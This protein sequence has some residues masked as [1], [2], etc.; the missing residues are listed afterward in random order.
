MGTEKVVRQYTKD[1]FAGRCCGQR[2]TRHVL[3][4]KRGILGV[5]FG[6]GVATVDSAVWHRTSL[7]TREAQL[8]LGPQT[9]KVCASLPKLERSHIWA[10]RDSISEGSAR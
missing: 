4:R 1:T 5:Y 7:F 10:Y 3:L 2:R 8:K 9:R 6:Q